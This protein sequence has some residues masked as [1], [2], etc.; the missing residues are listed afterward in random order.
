MGAALALNMADK[1]FDV[2]IHNRTAR[3]IHDLKTEAGSLAQRLV[4]CEAL[5]TFVAAIRPPRRIIMMVPAGDIVDQQIAALAPHLDE[6]DVIVDGGNANFRDT[7]RRVRDA[8]DKP[9]GIFGLGV[10]GGEDGA[11]HG[12]SLMGG[13]TE[14]AWEHLSDVLTAIAA[15]HTDGTPCAARLGAEGAGH[16][17]KMVHNGIEYADMQMIA[18]IHGLLHHGHGWS[19]E[20]IGTLLDR[21]NG[22]RLQS[23][24]VEITAAICH[25]T[26]DHTGKPLLDV[27]VDQAGQK[28]T[29]RWTAI[30]AQH[31]GVAVPVIEAAVAARN[32]SARRDMR[33]RAAGLFD[34]PTR[35]EDEANVDALEAALIAG[36]VIGYAQG[37]AMLAAASEAFDWNLK[38]ADVARVWRAGCIIRSAMLDDMAEAFEDGAAHLAFA[39]HFTTLIAD[40]IPA[41][42]AVT[43]QAMAA[44]WPVPCLSAALGWHDQLRMARGTAN[45]IQA[46]RDYFGRHGFKRFDMDGDHHGPWDD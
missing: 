24:L 12:P 33:E 7:N 46:Q 14:A 27:I 17:V 10:S 19:Y 30:E 18:E 4:A 39:P 43:T 13:G 28:G 45:V 8:A 1:G 20:D 23:Y 32:M 21:W 34:G 5:E 42:R 9:Y 11:R 36:K 3:R 6:G 25:A 31:L 44:G 2:A 29:G 26:D 37:F 40:Q 35:I 15:K 41:L 16:F 38:L 22:G